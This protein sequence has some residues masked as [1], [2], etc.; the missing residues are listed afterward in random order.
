MPLPSPLLRK[1]SVRRLVRSWRQLGWRQRALPDFIIIGAQKAGTGSLYYYLSEHP[2]IHPPLRKEIHYFDGGL[3][4]R[5]DNFARG[6]AWYRAHFP[7]RDRLEP[8]A[9]V[10]EASPLYLFNPLAPSRIASRL[11]GV[12]L[13]VLLR[14][15]VARA[16]SQYFMSLRRGFETL[17]LLEALQAEEARLAPVLAAGDYKNPLFIH[18]SYKMR[19][20]YAEQLKRFLDHF[21]REQLL[22]LDSG[23]FFRHPA[24][25][26]SRV[27]R[28]L[29][30]DDTFRPGNLKP[31]NVARNRGAVEEEAVAYLKDYFREP[32]QALRVLLQRDPGW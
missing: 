21:S 24:E 25:T 10:F 17:P 29:E 30:V 23:S 14:D 3:D 28:F 26:V 22:I 16:I 13:I 9:R 1:K 4:P 11:P 32:N 5:R 31:R 6:E 27:F 19:G 20:R 18:N 2:A 7:R 12:K 15:P 8:G